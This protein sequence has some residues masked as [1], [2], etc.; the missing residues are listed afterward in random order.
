MPRHELK[1]TKNTLTKEKSQGC[2]KDLKFYKFT[3]KKKKKRENRLKVEKHLVNIVAKLN[4]ML[5]G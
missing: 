5:Q 1:E 2:S 4:Q 3:K